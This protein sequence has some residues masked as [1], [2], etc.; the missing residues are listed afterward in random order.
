M[1]RKS[2]YLEVFLQIDKRVCRK[3]L[4]KCDKYF[5]SLTQNQGG[6]EDSINWEYNRFII[7]NMKQEK[8][9]K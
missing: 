3:A 2:G 1:R 9:N 8:K 5:K 4:E 7:K 6:D